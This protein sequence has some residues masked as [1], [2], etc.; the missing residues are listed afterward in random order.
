MFRTGRQSKRSFSPGLYALTAM[1]PILMIGNPVQA[2]IF[3][4]LSF[5]SVTVPGATETDVTGSAIRND[6]GKPSDIVGFYVDSSG[7]DHGFLEDAGGKITTVDVPG[8]TGTRIYGIE[9]TALY[10][11]GWYTDSKLVAHGFVRQQGSG[12]FKT[13][14]VPGAAWTQAYSVDI[15]G[16]VFGA[17]SDQAGVIHGFTFNNPFLGKGFTTVDFPKATGTEFHG[18]SNY[19]HGFSGSFIDSSGVEHGF[20]GSEAQFLSTI[21]FPG[22]GFTSVN[23]LNTGSGNFLVG[24]YGVSA[25]GPFHGFVTNDGNGLYQSIDFPGAVDTRCLGINDD[26]RITGR[27][28]DS[29][30]AVL[31]FFADGQL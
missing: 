16:T 19:G 2:Q 21:D 3:K 12:K 26:Y 30:G 24:Y 13:L 6:N 23:G 25:A 1:L 27:Y 10:I 22:A 20:L 31:G 15:E 29:T 11:T 14:D 17:Y 28:T 7:V 9:L 5:T 18:S 8:S 4:N